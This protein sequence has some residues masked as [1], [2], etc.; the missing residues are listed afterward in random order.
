MRRW[1]GYAHL[2]LIHMNEFGEHSRL[3]TFRSEERRALFT[4][5]VNIINDNKHFSIAAA[6][7]TADY[8]KHF[9]GVF[10][11]KKV[12]GVY[13]ACFLLLCAVQGKYLQSVNYRDTVPFV[14]DAGNPYKRHVSDAHSAIVDIAEGYA[15]ECRN[16]RLCFDDSTCALQAADIIAWSV[17]RRLTGAPLKS[18]FEP[19]SDVLNYEHIEETF[20][21][22]FMIDIADRIRFRQTTG[23]LARIELVPSCHAEFS[24]HH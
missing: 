13:G 4:D 7:S 6:L 3:G 22:Q 8:D 24:Q 19:I 5:L 1:L 14:L 11:K 9:E 17:R 15:N 20:H 10:D 21:S 16:S 18:G 23:G 2:P 12:M